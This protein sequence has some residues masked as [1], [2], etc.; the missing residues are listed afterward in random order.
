MNDKVWEQFLREAREFRS[1]KRKKYPGPLARPLIYPAEPDRKKFADDEQTLGRLLFFLYGIT[2][3]KLPSP[4]QWKE[5]ATKL[6]AQH[7][8]AFQPTSG[9]PKPKGQRGRPPKR[10]PLWF[11]DLVHE[12][13]EEIPRYAKS[14]NKAVD[15]VSPLTVISNKK[16]LA[17]W[18]QANG[19]PYAAGTLA[20]RYGET[21]KMM[22]VTRKRGPLAG[23]GPLV[24]LARLYK[25]SETD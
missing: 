4:A 6:A 23:F 20:S 21:K 11:I 18:K 10:G 14:H 1:G 16:F 17:K 24:E 5:L 8:P 3:N 22:E 13:D 2:F 19:K 25:N 7:V 12:V 15:K 9:P